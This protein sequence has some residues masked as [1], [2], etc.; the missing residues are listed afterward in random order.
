MD[1][2]VHLF[3]ALPRHGPCLAL[4][5][6]VLTLAFVVFLAPQR[7]FGQ[8]RVEQGIRPRDEPFAAN[9]GN[10]SLPTRAPRLGTSLIDGRVS[11]SA[12]HPGNGVPGR[13]TLG[14]Q[15]N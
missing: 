6:R 2:G 12:V 7:L 4:A 9:L 1:G 13:A 3:G 5:L 11:N 14:E 8:L 10:R 15:R